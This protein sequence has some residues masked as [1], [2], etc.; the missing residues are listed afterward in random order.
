[1][2]ST[3]GTT[4]ASAAVAAASDAGGLNLTWYDLPDDL[5]T[6]RPQMR[7]SSTASGTEIWSG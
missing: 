1:M 5:C 7:S 4:A 2:F 6:H 3:E